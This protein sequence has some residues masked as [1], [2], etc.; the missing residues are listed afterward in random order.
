MSLVSTKPELAHTQGHLRVVQLTDWLP[1]EFSAVSQYLMLMSKEQARAGADITVVGLTRGVSSK[2]TRAIGAGALTIVSVPCAPIDKARWTRRLL[3]T[4][5]TNLKILVSAWPHMRRAQSIRFTGSPPFLLYFIYIANLV[6]RKNLI[7][8][9]TDFYPECI[10]AAI[11]RRSLILEASRHLTN[12]LR[13]RI[14]EFEVIGVD[15]R[16]RLIECGID[17]ARI[18]LDRDHSPVEITPETV[19]M[20]RPDQFQHRK[21]LLYSGNWG[22]A[23]DIDTFFAGYSRHHE[24]GSGNVVLWLNATGSS[25]DALQ[26]RLENA[27]LP[28]FRQ[29]LVPLA[30]LASLLVAPDAHLIT[31]RPR[32]TGFVLPSKVYGCIASR[33]PI[34]FI[35]SQESDVHLL[36]S[37]QPNLYYRQID[38]G[39]P[40]FLYRTLEEIGRGDAGASSNVM[41]KIRR[42]NT[43]TD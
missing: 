9:I 37:A 3:W 2:E 39:D 35:G 26:R 8:R 10:I 21:L 23:H 38:I 18:R 29:K 43:I 22:V 6:L 19:P 27:G 5:Q 17:P 11:E 25:A 16:R 41:D 36:C 4:F 1:P 33:R 30:D 20:R 31:L 15:M 28:V 42:A 32:F 24:C 7:Y 40:E 14:D 34:I 12:A 13:R